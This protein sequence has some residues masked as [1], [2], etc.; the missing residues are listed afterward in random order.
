MKSGLLFKASQ[1]GL[2][3]NVLNSQERKEIIVHD[4][5]ELARLKAVEEY[6]MRKA[7]AL[8]IIALK[9]PIADL[10][11]KELKALMHNKKRKC[12]GAVPT[13]KKYLVG[14]YE[15]IFCHADQTLNTY[16]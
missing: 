1:L 2:A 13:S 4:T 3:S 5:R 9:K 14:R 12:D 6:T 8:K 10:G 16:L 7:T 15:A 11:V